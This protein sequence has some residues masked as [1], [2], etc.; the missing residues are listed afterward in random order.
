MTFRCLPL[1]L[2]VVLKPLRHLVEPSVVL[3]VPLSLVQTVV[4]N[5]TPLSGAVGVLELLHVFQ[6]LRVVT[7]IS[8]LSLWRSL[9]LKL[10]LLG[11]RSESYYSSSVCMVLT[12]VLSVKPM[13]LRKGVALSVALKLLLLY[14]V[15]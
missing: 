2:S 6:D 9:V 10:F 14:L 1:E 11:H 8:F 12:L 13:L 15:L 3:K 4:L 7:N 5:P